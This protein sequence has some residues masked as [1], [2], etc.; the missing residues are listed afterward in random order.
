[1]GG[2]D[3]ET[4]LYQQKLALNLA[5]YYTNIMDVWLTS[6]STT[7]CLSSDSSR[8][9]TGTSANSSGQKMPLNTTD[10]C[11]DGAH[12]DADTMAVPPAPFIAMESVPAAGCM[13][14]VNSSVLRERYLR[15][16]QSE[17]I[18]VTAKCSL[19]TSQTLLHYRQRLLQHG[20]TFVQE[21]PLECIREV[22]EAVAGKLMGH[23]CMQSISFFNEM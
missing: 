10:T 18:H 8:T 13:S 19:V 1:M 23:L 22:M 15:K 14:E 5:V 7:C 2:G 3:H 9:T 20:C 16:H 11:I 6:C 21:C 12:E 4:P 17:H